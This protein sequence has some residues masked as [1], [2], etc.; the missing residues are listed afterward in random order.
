[1]GC[2]AELIIMFLGR[3][4]SSE[5][6]PVSSAASEARDAS[7]GEPAA[8]ATLERGGHAIDLLLEASRYS[9]PLARLGKIRGAGVTDMRFAKRGGRGTGRGVTASAWGWATSTR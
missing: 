2:D 3:G 7:P 1:M 6:D 8:E 4:P 5:P 9:A